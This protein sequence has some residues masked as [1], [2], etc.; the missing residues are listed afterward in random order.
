MFVWNRKAFRT[1]LRA[2]KLKASWLSQGSGS[3][4]NGHSRMEE[5]SSTNGARFQLP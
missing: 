5:E 3:S 1:G 2:K 4:L